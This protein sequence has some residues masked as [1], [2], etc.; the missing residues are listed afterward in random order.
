VNGD[1]L[2]F[3]NINDFATWKSVKTQR[4]AELALLYGSWKTR[5]K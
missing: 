4:E 1:G 2:A 5:E 3:A